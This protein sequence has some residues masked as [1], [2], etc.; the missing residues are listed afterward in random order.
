MSSTP[1]FIMRGDLRTLIRISIPLFLFLFCEAFVVFY[2]RIL[3]S[4]AGLAAVSSSLNGA[5]LAF[6]FQGSCMAIASMAQVFVGL[7][8]GSGKLKQIGPC[9]WQL[10]WFSML[11]LAITLPL[12]YLSSLFYFKGTSIEQMGP[13][14][15]HILA[16]G[17]FLW[18]LNTALTSFY[19]G[20]GKTLFVTTLLLA[21]YAF[22]LILCWLLIFGVK[23]L[24]PSLGIQGAAL[25][26]C[27]SM[28]LFCL[29]FLSAFLNQKNREVYGTGCWHFSL[30]SLWSYIRP[31]MARAFSYFWMRSSWVIISY[32]MI[33]KGGLYLEVQTVGGI[34]T[35]FLAFLAGGIYRS[36]LTI[37]S[38]LL[39]RK[40]YSEVWKLYRSLMIYTCSIGVVLA[41]PFLLYP[42]MFAYFFDVSSREIYEK[43]SKLINHWLWLYVGLVTMQMGLCGLLV[44]IRD[45]KIQFY[46]ALLSCVTSLLPVYLAINFWRWAPDKLWLIMALENVILG[47][48]FFYRLRQRKW[49]EKQLMIS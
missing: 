27:L 39:G 2:E 46:S 29:I 21:S 33:T 36:V 37:A 11:S 26:K 41:I 24:I 22:N 35:A 13:Q 17:N 31:G 49:E 30:S 23:G 42:H 8:Q 16:L 9:V 4:H 25:A 32:T 1:N 44:A 10:I 12:S 15:F 48:L 40:D 34:I 14:Y 19:L 7:Y 38:N 47:F 3:L 6:I 20:R 5:Y 45:L 43:T 18:P 28:A